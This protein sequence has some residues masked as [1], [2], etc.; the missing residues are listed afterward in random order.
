MWHLP[1][2]K[3]SVTTARVRSS[4]WKSERACAL[5]LA[6]WRTLP[7]LLEGWACTRLR[8]RHLEL[9]SGSVQSLPRLFRAGLCSQV[10]VHCQRVHDSLPSL[11][12]LVLTKCVDKP[13]AHKAPLH[14][15]KW[16]VVI[17][18]RPR[19][20]QGTVVQSG[21]T[22]LRSSVSLRVTRMGTST[23]RQ[24]RKKQIKHTRN[25][26][27][28]KTMN[29]ATH[30]KPHTRSTRHK[31]RCGPRVETQLKL[32]THVSAVGTDIAWSQR[33]RTRKSPSWGKLTKTEATCNM[34]RGRRSGRFEELMSTFALQ[35]QARTWREWAV[36]EKFGNATR[37]ARNIVVLIETLFLNIRK[38]QRVSDLSVRPSRKRERTPSAPTLLSSHEKVSGRRGGCT[39]MCSEGKSTI[40][41]SRA[42]C[43]S[44]CHQLT[45]HLGHVP[46]SCL[47]FQSATKLIS[48]LSVDKNHI[49]V[50]AAVPQHRA[51]HQSARFLGSP[52]RE[53]VIAFLLIDPSL[54]PR[55][56]PRIRSPRCQWAA[57]SSALP[58]VSSSGRRDSCSCRLSSWWTGWIWK[59]P[60]STDSACRRASLCPNPCG[61]PNTSS[62]RHPGADSAHTIFPGLLRRSGSPA[63]LMQFSPRRT[64]RSQLKTAPQLA[65]SWSIP[66]GSVRLSWW[67][68]PTRIFEWPCRLT[69]QHLS[70]PPAHHSAAS[71]TSTLPSASQRGIDQS[72]WRVPGFAIAQH[73]CIDANL[74]SGRSCDKQLIRATSALYRVMSP[75]VSAWLS[76]SS[77][78]AF[79]H[80]FFPL[81]M[82]SQSDSLALSQDLFS[83]SLDMSLVCFDCVTFTIPFNDTIQH[84]PLLSRSGSSPITC[85]LISYFFDI[86]LMK[87]S[88]ADLSPPIVTSSPRTVATMSSSLMWPLHTHE[89]ALPLVSFRLLS[90]AASSSSQFCAASR[91]VQTAS[92][93]PT[94][95]FISWLVVR[96]IPFFVLERRST[97][98]AHQPVPQ[99]ILHV[100]PL[101]SPT[102]PL[103][104]SPGEGSSRTTLA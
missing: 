98:F 82:V 24:T 12:A 32:F 3:H 28:T 65:V 35:S 47:K 101:R 19:L 38:K 13:V 21:N 54:S 51:R 52:R 93:Q 99:P 1:R 7:R 55:H 36:H 70:M 68:P 67:P 22:T 78:S 53:H 74:S 26:K 91:A 63:L 37:R 27:N 20:C 94:H 83:I 69:S 16:T 72:S 17:C 90:E 100:H 66:W 6:S 81:H 23:K 59:P 71:K 84:S 34:R 60:V 102:A 61:W 95:V 45:L 49:I 89:H 62:L 86:I 43:T 5:I 87:H 96:R 79:C 30:K 40:H 56:P 85:F 25:N 64:A 14:A 31:R 92:Q 42:Q 29:S 41:R 11:P 48:A 77:L 2:G 8:N 50:T 75:F 9:W 4:C 44:M 57:K 18:T 10:S 33:K 15:T 80:P 39:A 88:T 104:A 103:S 76:G 46:D 97:P 73:T 58:V